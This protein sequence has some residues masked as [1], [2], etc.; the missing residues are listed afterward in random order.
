MRLGV[1]FL[2]PY[3]EDRS[4]WPYGEDIVD[5]NEWPVAQPFLVL[6]WYHSKTVSG[7]EGTD[8]WFSLWESLEH[9]PEH[10]EVLRNLPLRNPLIWL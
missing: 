5:W 10:A 2:V 6:A 7:T 9:F 1:D 3:I 4:M 8:R